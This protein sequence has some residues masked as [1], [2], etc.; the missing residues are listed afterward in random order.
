MIIAFDF[1]IRIRSV[2]MVESK[3]DIIKAKEV[4]GTNRYESSQS[5]DHERFDLQKRAY[6]QKHH[7]QLL[8]AA[9]I[10]TTQPHE[11]DEYD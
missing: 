8:F 9:A 11:L 4:G 3:A 2:W 7:G 6:N 10:L 5:F 1:T